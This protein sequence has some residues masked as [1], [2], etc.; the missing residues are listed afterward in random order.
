MKNKKQTR[1]LLQVAEDQGSS[2]KQETKKEETSADAL[3]S[4]EAKESMKLIH[5]PKS[6]RAL[7]DELDRHDNPFIPADYEQKLKEQKKRDEKE[8][9]SLKNFVYVDPHLLNTPVI[10]DLDNDGSD[11]IIFAV[12]YFFDEEYY[13][14]D[15]FHRS[16]LD[17][18]IDIHKYVAGGLVVYDLATMK[19]KWE[20]HLDLTTDR[21]NT[22]AHIYA[23]P[24]V[25]DIDSDGLLEVVIATSMGWIYVV[26]RKGKTKEGFP[27]LIGEMQ[28]QPIVEDVN[29]DGDVEICAG[30][31]NSNVVCFNYK[32]KVVWEKVTSG[33]LSSGLTA[34]DLDGDGILDIVATSTSGHIW[35]IKGDTGDVLPGFPVKT[36]GPILSSA[37]IL[38]GLSDDPQSATI[39]APSHDGYVYFVD[40]KTTCIDKFDIGERIYSQVLIDD[41]TGNGYL[42]LIVTTMNGN[43]LNL[44]TTVPYDPLKTITGMTPN[45]AYRANYHGLSVTKNSRKHRDEF[46]SSFKV[47]FDIV[48]N[49]KMPSHIPRRYTIRIT[50]GGTYELLKEKIYDKPG[51]YVVIV[52]TPSKR[53]HGKVIVSMVNEHGV[54]FED[55]FT[56]GFNIA[57]LN[58]FKWMI[59][60]PFMLCAG[61]LL[62]LF[63]TDATY[64]DSKKQ[65]HSSAVSG[66]PQ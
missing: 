25:A 37:S 51:R 46:G 5:I 63:G 24:I 57:F 4:A 18:D 49:R 39:I 42:N 22:R 36:D 54:R 35:A 8:F 33:R 13:A 2:T 10:V 26:D 48:D 1:K 32:G 59:V 31:A 3:L 52:P 11:D 43:V 9:G 58:L 27:I 55:E 20:L 28:G 30:D 62:Y 29:N 64:L 21:T 40:A 60:L 34:A 53:F 16:K 19:L 12:T 44:G 23:T 38:T 14:S 41:V 45:V 15:P 66:G 17:S 61:L 47:E 50:I 65:Q 7:I 56:L 6:M